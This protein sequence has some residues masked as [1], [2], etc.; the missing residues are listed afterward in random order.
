MSTDLTFA[1]GRFPQAIRFVLVN[2]CVPHTDQHRALCG[3]LIEKGYV[4][5]SQTL[6]PKSE[7]WDGRMYGRFAALPDQAEPLQRSRLLAALSVGTAIIQ[8]RHMAPRTLEQRSMP[9]WSPS[10]GEK[11]QSR[12]RSCATRL[13]PRR[14]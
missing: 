1:T 12:S 13:P 9:R 14:F 11:A 4:R 7:E 8:L 5:D 6:L 3:G 10:R 2:N